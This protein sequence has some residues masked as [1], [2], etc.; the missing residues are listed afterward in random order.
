M[1]LPEWLCAKLRET[2]SELCSPSS[3]GAINIADDEGDAVGT[4]TTTEAL[5]P[6]LPSGVSALTRSA[7]FT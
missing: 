2:T 3:G 4:V 5:R 1:P 7:E 6:L